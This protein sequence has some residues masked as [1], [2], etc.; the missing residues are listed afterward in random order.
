MQCSQTLA[1]QYVSRL[2][3][4]HNIQRDGQTERER[5]RERARERERERERAR[6]RDPQSHFLEFVP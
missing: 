6:E 4:K 1:V 2:G 3:K 5:E